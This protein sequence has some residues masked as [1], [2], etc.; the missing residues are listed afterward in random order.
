MV[1]V[2]CPDELPL[3]DGLGNVHAHC[4]RIRAATKSVLILA[5]MNHLTGLLEK[6]GM[7]GIKKKKKVIYSQCCNIN[8][9]TVIVM[10]SYAC[11]RHVQEH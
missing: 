3:L 2:Y 6:D 8:A 11:V 7:L 9:F 4:P 10:L 5:V 1:T